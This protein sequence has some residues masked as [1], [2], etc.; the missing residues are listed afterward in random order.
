MKEGGLGKARSL[1]GRA[2]RLSFLQYTRDSSRGLA[3]VQVNALIMGLS[4]KERL[5]RFIPNR[6]NAASEVDEA[7]AVNSGWQPPLA[8]AFVPSWL[9]VRGTTS[10]QASG[11]VVRRAL[12]RSCAKSSR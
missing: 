8:W 10:R 12:V 9:L 2:S 11:T 4:L 1:S 5:G 3:S 7:C 6:T